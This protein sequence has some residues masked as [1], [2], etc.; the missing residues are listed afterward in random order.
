[1]DE[2]ARQLP[3]AIV[4]LG[5]LRGCSA[6]IPAAIHDSVCKYMRRHRAEGIDR[7]SVGPDVGV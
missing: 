1:M 7:K 6:Q 3:R 4:E 2:A 5:L